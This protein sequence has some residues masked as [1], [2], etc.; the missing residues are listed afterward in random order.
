MVRFYLVT[1]VLLCAL[2]VYAGMKSW[3]V[4]DPWAINGARPTGPAVI[5]TS[6]FGTNKRGVVSGTS[7]NSQICTGSSGLL[8]PWHNHSVFIN[9]SI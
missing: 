3:K 2:F 7:F 4:I 8:R 9:Q 5:I 1:G 6:K